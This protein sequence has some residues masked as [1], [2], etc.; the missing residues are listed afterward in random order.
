MKKD[1]LL[2]Y[3]AI[4]LIIALSAV[5][6]VLYD[7]NRKLEVKNKTMLQALTLSNQLNQNTAS[8]Y[9]IFGECV[10]KPDTCN[11]EETEKKLKELET[12]KEQINSQIQNI[13]D[14]LNL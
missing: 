7:A 13:T 9:K 8:A 5:I 11:K 4:I 2:I 3:T 14:N 12:E 10:T 1:K 6:F